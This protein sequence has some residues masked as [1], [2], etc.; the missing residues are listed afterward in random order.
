[1]EGH[2]L[3]NS[4]VKISA[5]EFAAKFRSKKEIFDF[6]TVEKKAYLSP[7]HTVSIYFLK[8]ISSGRKSRKDNSFYHA[9]L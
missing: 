9:L 8:D 6:L 4:T 5:K 3:L 7:Y 2:Q 1:M